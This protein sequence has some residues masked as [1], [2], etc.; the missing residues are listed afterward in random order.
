MEGE[1]IIAYFQWMPSFLTAKTGN[2]QIFKFPEK[3][4]DLCDRICQ[5]RVVFCQSLIKKAFKPQG[6]IENEKT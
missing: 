5:I 4:S 3:K 2:K 6:G 1:W